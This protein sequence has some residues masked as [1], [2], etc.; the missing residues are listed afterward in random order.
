MMLAKLA[1]QLK[2]IVISRVATA[3]QNV[4]ASFSVLIKRVGGRSNVVEM[5]RPNVSIRQRFM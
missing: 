2:S 1:Q 5:Q 3:K 4:I